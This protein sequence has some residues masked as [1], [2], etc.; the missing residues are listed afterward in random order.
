MF[1]TI[2]WRFFSS[3]GGCVRHHFSVI[4]W[5]FAVMSTLIPIVLTCQIYLWTLILVKHRLLWFLD[6]IYEIG[7]ITF[8]WAYIKSKL[9]SA[10]ERAFEII[11]MRDYCYILHQGNLS[12]KKLEWLKIDLQ[13]Y[14]T[15]LEAKSTGHSDMCGNDLVT[16]RLWLIDMQMIN[17]MMKEHGISHIVKI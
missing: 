15:Y 3:P 14:Y 4:T 1:A 9:N 2:Y 17:V 7:I 12:H 11:Q 8:L 5:V 13:I 10:I 6:L 16:Y